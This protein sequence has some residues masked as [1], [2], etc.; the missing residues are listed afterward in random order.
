M[1]EVMIV[2]MGEV[3]VVV[4]MMMNEMLMMEVQGGL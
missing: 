2:V 1:G 3:I 4:E